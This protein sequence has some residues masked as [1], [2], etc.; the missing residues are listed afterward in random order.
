MT[1]LRFRALWLVCLLAF[2]LAAN[3][4][5]VRFEQGSLIIPMQ[6]AYQSQ[7]G[8]TAAYGL[9]YR[10][11]QQGVTV[12]WAVQPNKSSHHRCKNDPAATGTSIDGCDMQVAKDTGRPVS[13]LKNATGVF[14]D[15]FDTFDTSANPNSTGERAFKVDVNRKLLR[16]MGGPFIID[17][18]DAAKAV[19]LI[20]NHADFALFR[21]PEGAVDCAP[22]SAFNVRVHRVNNA[23]VGPVAR[24]M[25]EVPPPIAL[26]KG[27]NTTNAGSVE[28]LRQYLTNAGLNFTGAEGTFTNHGKIF[29]VLDQDTDLIST[30]TYPKG[31]LNY[32][33]DSS[34]PNKTYYKVMWSPH[35]E[36]DT[37]TTQKQTN[38]K[39]ALSNISHFVDLGNSIFN[40]CASIATY[41]DSFKPDDKTRDVYADNGPTQFMS[42]TDPAQPGVG[43]QTMT[44]NELVGNNGFVPNGQ[45]C[46]DPGRSGDCYVF[47]NY[48]DLFSQ[49]GD[50]EFSVTFGAV[51]GFRPRKLQ[52]Y[53]PGTL[54]MISTKSGTAAKDGW[55]LYI[56]RPK[57]NNRQKGNVLYL[58]GHSLA[59]S[60]AGNRIVLNTLLNLAYKPQSLETS[61]SEPVADVTYKSDGSVDQMHVLSGTY[62]YTPPQ[63]LFPERINFMSDQNAI[64]SSKAADWVFPYIEGRFRS[65]LASGIDT[66]RQGF[67][68]NAEWEATERMPQPG[69][70]TLF[71]VLGSNQEGLKRVPF[72]LEQLG[73][74][75]VDAPSTGKIDGVCDLQEALTLD[76]N[77]AGSSWLDLDG[78]GRID[79]TVPTAKLSELNHVS[80]HFVQRV[81]GFCVAHDTT[82]S[83]PVDTMTPTVSDC[84]NRQFGE[85]RATLGGLDH[86]SSAVVGPSDYIKAPRP[87]VIYIG[88]LD[89]QLHALYLRGTQP[90]FSPPLPG[91]ELWAFIPKGQLSRLRTNNARVDVSP[92][93]TDVYVDYADK[94]DDGVLSPNERNTGLYRWRTVLI[95][96]SGRLGGEMFALDVTNPLKPVVLWD[97]TAS[98][99][100]TDDPVRTNNTAPLWS[101]RTGVPAP[102]YKDLSSAVHT[103]PYNYTDLGDSLDMNLVPVRRGNRP[104]FQVIVSTNG[105]RTG[106]QQL[107]VFALDAGTGKKLW[108]WER[109]YGA[110]TSNSVPGGTSTLDVDGDGSMDR[111]YVGDMEGRLWE[112]SILTGVNL[113]Y[114][115]SVSGGPVSYPLFATENGL[116]PISTVPAIM[117]LPYNLDSGPFSTLGVGKA[118]AGKLALVF[119]TAGPDW[120]LA[121]N[122][123]TK[124][125]VYVVA[126]SPEDLR[127]RD[128]L[129]YDKV[130]QVLSDLVG[131]MSQRGTAKPGAALFTELA[132]KERAVGSPKLVGSKIVLTTAYGTTESDPFSSDMQGRTH[133]LDLSQTA[134]DKV[135]SE[136]G[137]AAA[138]GLVLPDGSIITQSMV[139]LQ[140]TPPAALGGAVPTTGLAGRRTQA[141]VGSWLDLG[142]A[143]A[144]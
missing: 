26:V 137:K 136:S 133:V 81:R 57:D 96:G 123:V 127:I 91:T 60:A 118:A 6:K 14:K 48:A 131:F 112:L 68:K 117:R 7:C 39:S 94:D 78:N 111:V 104:S 103:G 128:Q 25:N 45:D 47:N 82:D 69:S 5:D 13:L 31:K 55:D 2:P 12:Y 115:D 143:L 90:N 52:S 38:L 109:P 113:N 141:R 37:S 132:E 28:I 10:L 9:V 106:A 83:T 64:M 87:E 70:R 107:Q 139:G 108:Q 36:G 20:K 126:S 30:G 40:E 67:N 95:S 80:Q 99:D 76:R 134:G 4:T 32:A 138:G 18:T 101:D 98:V 93:V 71:T 23:F 35:W 16:Y 122:S 22:G 92:V 102:D 120:V 74:R 54:R 121:R 84:D 116:H 3:A 58:A 61:R 124:G 41:E 110:L 144:E 17:A 43:L 8:V 50:F 135:V 119:G 24:I 125:R 49:K 1:A 46:S 27:R 63:A 130:N 65:L 29:D 59:A 140:R 86:A 34:T 51:E 89:G 53:G 11:L 77:A 66:S 79:I 85:V 129:S 142:R 19:D 56:S 73:T 97:V 15:D 72:S 42:T 75:C 105:A 33:P 88:G 44:T 62:L 100:N 114:F 21:G